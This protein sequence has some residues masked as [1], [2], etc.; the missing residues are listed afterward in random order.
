[1]VHPRR[2]RR[3]LAAAALA[4]WWLIAAHGEVVAGI[5]LLWHK[6]LPSDLQIAH[7][8]FSA[9]G[10]RL[11]VAAVPGGFPQERGPA[12]LVCSSSGREVWRHVFPA[13]EYLGEMAISPDGRRVFC[14]YWTDARVVKPFEGD[15][16]G[17]WKKKPWRS[18]IMPLD[19]VAYVGGVYCF[20]PTGAVLWKKRWKGVEVG[21]PAAS[22]LGAVEQVTGDRLLL[23]QPGE[24]CIDGLAV[25]NFHGRVLLRRRF[26]QG[27]SGDAALF[28]D[29]R[30]L[31]IG[32][33]DKVTIG[34]T[35]GKTLRTVKGLRFEQYG[36]P[37]RRAMSPDGQLL[38]LYSSHRVALI[39]RAGR[40]KWEYKFPSDWSASFVESTGP[41]A[42]QRAS[43]M[44]APAIGRG[45]HGTSVLVE[46][47]ARRVLFRFPPS[48]HKP[49]QVELRR[50]KEP[51]EDTFLSPDGTVV[52]FIRT[53]RPAGASGN[54]LPRVTLVAASGALLGELDLPRLPSPVGPH[55]FLNVAFSTPAKYLAISSGP[56]LYF[57]GVTR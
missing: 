37:I 31:V 32:W 38:A 27:A 28:P 29:G 1:M 41:N 18:C 4:A 24:E 8:A 3:S 12:L 56:Q 5:R 45:P 44:S 17:R 35:A 52:A 33:Y 43:F 57:V 55:G 39:D 13:K 53:E 11:A 26:K 36:R 25:L 2:C 20:G 42:G 50:F 23:V 7:S 14:D 16:Q 51:Y 47:G 21:P 9:S 49:E 46:R 15:P 22:P 48:S 19:R 34:S 10:E 54:H 40:L 30:T 6:S